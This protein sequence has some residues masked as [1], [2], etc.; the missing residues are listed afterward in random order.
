[1]ETILVQGVKYGPD[2]RRV[3][4]YPSHPGG[5]LVPVPGTVVPL[6]AGGDGGIMAAGSQQYIG[7]SR[8]PVDEPAKVNE[9]GD[10]LTQEDFP[11]D[12]RGSFKPTRRPIMFEWVYDPQPVLVRLTPEIR[13][14]L[15]RG[16]IV[17]VT[18]ED[19]PKVKPKGK[20]GGE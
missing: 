16:E 17:A 8:K 14:A 19:K 15:A 13:R 11:V 3:P 12:E 4:R 10:V 20:G 9:L 6:A 2:D 18:P 1:M 5:P 7:W